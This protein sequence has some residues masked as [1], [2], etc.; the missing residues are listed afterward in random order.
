M[1]QATFFAFLPTLDKE[2]RFMGFR[3]FLLIQ[4]IQKMS[5]LGAGIATAIF[6][7]LSFVATYATICFQ[8][9]CFI[10]GGV[11]AILLGLIR[12]RWTWTTPALFHNLS[13]IEK[14][15]RKMTSNTWSLRAKLIAAVATQGPVGP[16]S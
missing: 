12:D 3:R 4:G 7:L 10:A 16:A 13:M 14:A 2:Y 5:A 15:L 8:I 6:C 1:P 11:L 9:S